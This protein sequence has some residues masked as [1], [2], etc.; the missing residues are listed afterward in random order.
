MYNI[1]L[2]NKPNLSKCET[3]NCCDKVETI[4]CHVF[5][6]TITSKLIMQIL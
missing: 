4:N 2:N 3:G 1:K 6:L 5:L